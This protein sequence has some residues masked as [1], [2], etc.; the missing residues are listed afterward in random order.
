M[1]DRQDPH[2]ELL[3]AVGNGMRLSSIM[4]HSSVFNLFMAS[5]GL[6]ESNLY[7]SMQRLVTRQF[8]VNI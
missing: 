7:Q 4:F 2:S 1:V 6:C 8:S 3:D 5:Y